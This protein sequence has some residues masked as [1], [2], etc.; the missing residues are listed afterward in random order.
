MTKLI[1]AFRSF[2][3]TPKNKLIMLCIYPWI[4]G[5]WFFKIASMFNLG[6]CHYECLRGQHNAVSRAIYCPRVTFR[7][8]LIWNFRVFCFLQIFLPN[9]VLNTSLFSRHSK[10]IACLIL[11]D[12][13]LL[14]L[15]Y[16]A[17]KWKSY[18]FYLCSFLQPVYILSLQPKYFL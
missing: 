18:S 14:I 4:N 6:L 13:I 11:F 16:L 10:C 15:G 17:E 5:P 2:S 9:V 7:A 3:N 8:G 12:L 1:V